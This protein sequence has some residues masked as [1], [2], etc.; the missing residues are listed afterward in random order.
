MKKI[1]LC[2]LAA[3]VLLLSFCLT[4][5]NTKEIDE[6]Y[7]KIVSADSMEI[8]IEISKLGNDLDT[9]I[10][11][12]GDKIHYKSFDKEWCSYYEDGYMYMYLKEGS[13]WK[14][15]P[16]TFVGEIDKINN[17]KEEDFK[18]ILNGKNYKYSVKEKAYV[19]KA[20]ADLPAGFW[21]M[22]ASDYVLRTDGESLE[23]AYVSVVN[24]VR[25]DVK[26]TIKNLN[27]TV[28]ELP[29]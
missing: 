16:E 15:Y 24:G 5:C 25:S 19:A 9:V 18:K 4:A 29:F 6:F 7:D 28:V 22:A 10:K 13:T 2:I 3:V 11:M 17:V 8:V 27:E 21:S 1:N 20:N 12:D 23:I 14:K 26:M